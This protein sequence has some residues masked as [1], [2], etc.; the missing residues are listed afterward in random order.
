MCF[1]AFTGFDMWYFGLVS[2]VP[3]Y[4]AT[5][6]LPLKKTFLLTLFM[7]TFAHFGGYY[8]LPETMI[9]F[10]GFPWPLAFLFSLILN[11]YQGTSFAIIVTLIAA[12]RR[13]KGF[14]S[15]FIAAAIFCAVEQLYPRIFPIYWG[16]IMYKVHIAVQ[17]VDLFGVIFISFLVA[18]VNLA[19]ANAILSL[20]MKK[21]AFQKKQIIIVAA[22]WAASLVYGAVRTNQVKA[23]MAAAETV[24]IGVVQ[25][26]MGISQKHTAPREGLIRHRKMSIEL[27]KQK[28]DLLLW[29]ESSVNYALPTS[30]KSLKKSVLGKVSTPTIF[31]AIRTEEVEGEDRVRDYNTAFLV[32]G[33]GKVLGT[34]DKMY[35]LAFGEYIP[36]GETFPKL[37]EWSP[38]TGRFTPGKSFKPVILPGV[39]TIGVLICYEDILPG[40]VQKIMSSSEKEIDLLVNITNDAWFGDTKEPWIHLGLATFRSIEQRRWLIRSTNSGVSAAIDPIGRVVE[41]TP[42]MKQVSFVIDAGLLEIKT[43][44]RMGG[45]LFGY[46]CVAFSLGL[47]AFLLI[48]RRREKSREQKAGRPVETA[49][50]SQKA[51]AK[52]TK[53]GRKKK[54][55]KKKGQ[56]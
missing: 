30:A 31:G 1:L 10:G 11:A 27:E 23:A 22:L 56:R 45:W 38:H 24:R 19:L 18:L 33:D 44:Y 7:G 39:A 21:T 13:R 40:L 48:T 15:I 41:A 5:H 50:G 6:D 47:F 20:G 55:G 28:I 12:V 34:Y 37:Y 14:G 26:N 2:W 8:W 9:Q 25:G 3:L 53:K 54:P 29:S 49:A 46:L 32:D 35:L 51:P 17:S 36:L 42:V 43:L 4:I 16:N 52:K